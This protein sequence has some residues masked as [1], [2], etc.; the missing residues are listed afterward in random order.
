MHTAP[1][2]PAL[3]L[4]SS[5][6]VRARF[7]LL[8]PAR[9]CGARWRVWC[10]GKCA[11]RIGPH[12]PSDPRMWRSRVT[13]HKNAENQMPSQYRLLLG[14]LHILKYSG[15]NQETLILVVGGSDADGSAFA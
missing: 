13:A 5:V 4:W 10:V 15:T 9:A 2:Y 8:L 11:P 1:L 12:H 6:R 7:P 14:L 3:P